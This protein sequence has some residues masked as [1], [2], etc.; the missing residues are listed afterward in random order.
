LTTEDVSTTNRTFFLGS[1][2]FFARMAI[3][4]V[5][6]IAAFTFVSHHTE[7]SQYFSAENL[8]TG[9]SH[10]GHA[11]PLMM[12]KVIPTGLIGVLVAGL[13]AA[14][15]STHDSYLLAWASVISQDIVAPLKGKENLSDS[16]SIWI[17]R[18]SVVVIGLFL[19]VWGIWY[20]LPES[21]W[22]YMGV[23]GT[24]Y[25]SGTAPA[26]IGGMY[27]K[28]AST[29][30]AFWSL[31]GGLFA[32][33]VLFLKPIQWRLAGV[34]TEIEVLSPEQ[35]SAVDAVAYWLNDQSVSLSVFGLCVVLFVS[36]SL[37]FP[38]RKTS[39]ES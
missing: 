10:P 21:V 5:W 12:G 7:L 33:P 23:T 18:V 27:W 6:G 31:L 24:I 1:P 19:L 3:P 38:D 30:G 16:Q 20:E 13:M 4:A 28:R 37:L 39:T 15:M 25:L 14:F 2:G 17:T 36:G 35:Q 29:T 34:P 8:A 11:M 32:V 9:A 22:T 26:M